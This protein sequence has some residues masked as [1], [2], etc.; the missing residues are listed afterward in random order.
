MTRNILREDYLKKIEKFI[1]KPV[2]KVITGI[3][4]SGKSYFIKQ[5][6]NHL[7]ENGVSTNDILYINKELFEFDFIKNY[8]D[9]YNY[10][11]EKFKGN[12][13]FKYIFIDEIQEITEWE[14]A[15]SSFFAEEDYD[16]YLTG[17]NSHLLSSEISTL[18][19]GRYVEI[20][21]YTLSF[22]EFL[23][24]RKLSN[25]ILS[26][27]FNLYLRFGGFPVIHNFDLNEEVTYQYINSIYSTIIL[28][29]VIARHNIRNVRLFQ[30]IVRFAIDNLGQIFSG[31]SINKYLKNQKKNVGIDTIQNYLGFLESSFLLH[32]VQR[33]DLKGKKILNLFEKY[34]L[35]D[36]SI[37]NALFGYN[38]ESISGLLENI[39][40]LKL[41]QDGY[42]VYIGKLDDLKV[43]F[44]AERQGKRKY[45]QVTYLLQLEQTIAREYGVLEKIKDNYPKYILSMDNLPPSDKNGIIRMNIIDFLLK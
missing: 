28:K 18:I 27:E 26:D 43:D 13:S 10:I 25:P 40:F 1:G 39:V 8:K 45:I 31:N 15:V 6:I 7:Q 23:K 2:I 17:S 32:K 5:V 4:R 34:Y 22:K 35:G 44:I 41:K 33:Y 36:I 12:N 11:D 37:K 29:D 42:N 30:D 3:R 24:F 19:S 16:I 21:I 14:K 38:D 9:L 20:N